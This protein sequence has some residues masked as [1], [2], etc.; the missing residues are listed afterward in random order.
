MVSHAAFTGRVIHVPWLPAAWIG[1][2]DCHVHS[3]LDF[4][5]KQALSILDPAQGGGIGKNQVW[6]ATQDGN[7]PRIPRRS[8]PV[9]N[10]GAIRRKDRAEFDA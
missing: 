8:C 3:V 7:F 4:G 2:D 5:K 6:L 9:G 10:A 1:T